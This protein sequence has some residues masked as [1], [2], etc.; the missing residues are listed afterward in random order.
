MREGWN[1][2]SFHPIATQNIRV[3]QPFQSFSFS[4]FMFYFKVF[5]VIL[6]LTFQTLYFNLISS[7]FLQPH[8]SLCLQSSS[9][10]PSP[11]PHFCL[12]HFFLHRSCSI[13]WW[14]LWFVIPQRRQQV[15]GEGEGDKHTNLPHL[16]PTSKGK[17]F[18]W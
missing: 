4:F 10:F 6:S 14:R 16:R 7:P 3:L 1:C 11:K 15:F 5:H 12:H 9:S 13:H 17:H 2:Y 8:L 18:V